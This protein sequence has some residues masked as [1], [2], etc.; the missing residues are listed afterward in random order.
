[1]MTVSNSVP[2]PYRSSLILT[3]TALLLAM[4][5]TMFAGLV[6]TALAVGAAAVAAFAAFRYWQAWHQRA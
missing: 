4:I 5:S 1:M 6:G 2:W 3:A